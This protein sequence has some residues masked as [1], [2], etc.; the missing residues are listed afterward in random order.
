VHTALR[1]T[2]GVYVAID[3]DAF[4]ESEVAAFMPEPDGVK[5]SEVERLLKFVREQ[6]PILGVGFSGLVAREENL[7]PISRLTAALG[8]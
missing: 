5:V 7:Q 6:K 2:E 1:D 4:D 3:F 8:F